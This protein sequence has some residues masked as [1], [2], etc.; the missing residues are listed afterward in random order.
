[1][2]LRCQ[3]EEGEEPTGRMVHATKRPKVNLVQT[4]SISTLKDEIVVPRGTL[5]TCIAGINLQP[6]DVGAAIQFLEFC[7]SFGEICKIGKGLPEE[8]LKDLTQLEEVSSVVADVHINLLS[9]IENGK[10]K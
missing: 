4:K 6:E 3:K 8:I 1:M 2:G 5:V 7:R 10:Y 9:I